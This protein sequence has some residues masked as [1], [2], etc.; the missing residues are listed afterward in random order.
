MERKTRVAKSAPAAG[1]LRAAEFQLR[2][3]ARE[4]LSGLTQ[5]VVN[6]A[7]FFRLLRV[8]YPEQYEQFKAMI[9]E[10]AISLAPLIHPQTP[11]P[12]LDAITETIE[13][14]RNAVSE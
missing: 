9:Q 1:S 4:F 12:D 11:I 13:T 8:A 3:I 6:N 5:I 10:T 2:R 14:D 7:A